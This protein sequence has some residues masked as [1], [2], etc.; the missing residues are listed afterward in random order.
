[1]QKRHDCSRPALY[2]SIRDA[3]SAAV[4]LMT[5]LPSKAL[6]LRGEGDSA[7]A[8]LGFSAFQRFDAALGPSHVGAASAGTL[9]WHD[10]EHDN[11]EQHAVASQRVLTAQFSSRCVHARARARDL[12]YYN[13]LGAT[14]MQDCAPADAM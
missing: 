3:Y 12:F 6:P 5:I 13:P 14:S 7:A 2:Y 1:M 8:Q 9:L 10:V 4:Q 11:S